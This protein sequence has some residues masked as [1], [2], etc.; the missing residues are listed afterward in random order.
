[1]PRLL[2]LLQQQTRIHTA[3]TAADQRFESTTEPVGDTE[4]AHAAPHSGRSQLGTPRAAAG[5]KGA[6]RRAPRNPNRLLVVGEAVAEL[7][8]GPG[9]QAGDVH[10]GDAELGRDLGLGQVAEEPE[11]E[12][13]LLARWQAFQQ[14]LEGLAGLAP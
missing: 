6:R 1:M 8:E 3:G 9:Q 13:L 4:S 2:L 11:Q 5:R 7:G 10:L 14:W 12:D